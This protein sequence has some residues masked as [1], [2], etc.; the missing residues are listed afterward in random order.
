MKLHYS[1]GKRDREKKQKKKKSLGQ[2]GAEGPDAGSF[3]GGGGRRPP[4]TRA[5]TGAPRKKFSTKVEKYCMYL[6]RVI[7]VNNKLLAGR[8]CDI[9]VCTA[10]IFKPRDYLVRGKSVF[11]YCGII[12]LTR[13]DYTIS[14]RATFSPDAFIR[15][16]H[17]FERFCGISASEI[18]SNNK[19]TKEN[20]TYLVKKHDTCPHG[21][22]L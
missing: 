7:C 18:A 20:M 17:T 22:S 14:R 12:L 9:R 11:S 16:K 6:C 13:P 15:C 8:K 19:H 5:N 1:A 4:T 3:Y 21:F 2:G 10:D